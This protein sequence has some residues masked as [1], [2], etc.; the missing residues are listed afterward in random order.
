MAKYETNLIGNFDELLNELDLGI[1]SRSQTASFEAASNYYANGVRCSV[2]VYER[3]SVFGSNRLS[4]TISLF[5]YGRE[6]FVSAI[7]SGGSQAMF[8][9][10]NTL[11]EEAFL[12][13][14]VDV[15]EAYIA[16]HRQS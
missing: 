6:L 16:S 8:F 4:M 12:K 5:G 9:K 10:I 13:H 15:I 14:A 11:G 3:Y 2:R 1:I 7:S